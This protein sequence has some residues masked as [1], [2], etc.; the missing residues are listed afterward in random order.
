MSAPARE[1]LR[2]LPKVE[3]H[4][5]FA[6]TIRPGRLVAWARERGVALASEDPADLARYTGLA[7]FLR[8]FNAAHAV[9]RSSDDIALVAHEGVRA[10]VATTNLRYREY[11]VN[12]GNFAELG[13]PWPSVLA[14]LV[15]GLTR[16]EQEFGVGFG[17]VPAINRA[18]DLAAA[19]AVLDVVLAHPHPAV[20][21]LGQDDLA[22]DGY[23]S[24]TAWEPV[25]R[26]AREA[27]LR[28]TAH[29][30][31]IATSTAASVLEAVEVLQLD[32]VDHGYHVVD[33]PV[34]V[35]RAREAGV[36][37]CCTPTSAHLLSGWALDADH[38]VARMVEAGL[39]VN[40]STDD[41]VFFD[42]SLQ[43][44]YEHVG[45]DLG[46]DRQALERIALDGVEAS[47]AP[48]ATRER[49]RAEVL[50]LTGT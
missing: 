10:A 9:F 1:F 38:P 43:A 31:E 26:R 39:S 24:P 47:F 28:T 8:S 50:A 32:R 12:P 37:F 7:D 25:Y 22:A 2:A 44:E 19:H 4:C 6:S 21:G 45:L 20:V 5:H 23:E 3:L 36:H 40:L 42:T 29:V 30:G 41:E 49:L 34:A 15:Q 14:G 46:L 33:D 11:H 13:L 18:R 27:G 17:I 16:A 48:E 35:D